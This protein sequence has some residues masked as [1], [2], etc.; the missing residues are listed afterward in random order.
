MSKALRWYHKLG[1]TILDKA[2]IAFLLFLVTLDVSKGLSEVGFSL[3]TTLVIV[4]ILYLVVY[5]I[6]NIPKALILNRGKYTNAILG[7]LAAFITWLAFPTLLDYTFM[8]TNFVGWTDF[9]PSL[10][11]RE[12]LLYTFVIRA[13]LIYWLSRRLSQ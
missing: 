5:I 2:I 7:G 1:L 8:F 12:I 10:P 6:A 9:H 11:L 13:G 3:L 4:L